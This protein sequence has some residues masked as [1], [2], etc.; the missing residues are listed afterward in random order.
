[1]KKVLKII[2][3]IIIAICFIF[4]IDILS[5]N[6]INKPLLMIKKDNIYY[7]IGYKYVECNNDL[8]LISYTTKYICQINKG[9]I[10]LLDSTKFK[11]E[12]TNVGENNV[13]VYRNINEIISI[14]NNGTG[15]IYLG[16]PECKW[17]QAYVP[18]LNEVAKE[19]NLEKIYYF[20]ILEDR[21][22]NTKEY[23]QIV[24]ILKD[25]LNYDEEGKKRIYVPTV[26]AIKEGKIIGFDDETSLDTKNLDDPKDYWTNEEIK[27]LK[28]K[29]T[30]MIKEVN[31][32]I[33]T[34]CNK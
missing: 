31:S 22:N 16:F 9:E 5:V 30:K 15:I 14:L 2:L 17:C 6:L 11:N 4:L 24:D 10:S 3:V 12:Y 1:M 13:F 34:E 26:I 18:Y 8:V 7:G 28:E 20:N 29:L 25:Y 27:D 19:F 23:L 33:C 21:K 32:M